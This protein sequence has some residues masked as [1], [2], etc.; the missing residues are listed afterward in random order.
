[1]GAMVLSR[2]AW[3]M[4]S[5]RWYRRSLGLGVIP[6]LG[7]CKG[8]WYLSLGILLND[9]LLGAVEEVDVYDVVG[10]GSRSYGWVISRPLL[11]NRLVFSG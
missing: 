11:R 5:R 7:A 8:S 2:H 3:G 1:M 6:G 10:A 9:M 4:L